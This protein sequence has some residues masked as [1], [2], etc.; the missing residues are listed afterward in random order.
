MYQHYQMADPTLVP[1]PYWHTK[2]LEFT[3]WQEHNARLSGGCQM[4]PQTKLAPPKDELI[5]LYMSTPTEVSGFIEQRSVLARSPTF[6]EF[7][8]SPF[9]TPGMA[10][11]IWLGREHPLVVK[12]ALYYLLLHNSSSD[13]STT[14]RSSSTSSTTSSPDS[15][16]K[17]STAP[18]SASDGAPPATHDDGEFHTPSL[19]RYNPKDHIYLQI[20]LYFLAKRLRLWRLE[21]I[22]YDML[23]A[24]ERRIDAREVVD[25]AEVIYD[26][27]E[28]EDARIRLF[29]NKCVEM[30]L[31]ALLHLPEWRVLLCEARPSLAADM[32]ELLSTLILSG[33]APTYPLTL[34]PPTP[35]P[36][37]NA[38]YPTFDPLNKN[39]IAIAMRHYHS[40]D[41]SDLNISR[42]DTLRDCFVGAQWVV[43]T[44][45]RGGRGYFPRDWVELVGVEGEPEEALSGGESETE[46]VGRKAG[47]VLGLVPGKDGKLGRSVS[48]KVGRKRGRLEGLRRKWKRVNGA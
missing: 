9:F 26:K 29:L 47:S 32:V 25:L 1:G 30:N 10:T 2:G 18:S 45:R 21:D 13:P 34:P 24:N 20:R 8:N 17:S 36:H 41:P 7:F 3:S 44:D 16:R 15:G 46:G 39:I 12:I 37:T 43:G 28:E 40:T 6:A 5:T 27:D 31:R 35:F 33:S 38:S 4:K 23:R 14:S 11:C 19:Q 22:A 48:A 42:G